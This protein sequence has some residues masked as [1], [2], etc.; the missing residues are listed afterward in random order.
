M[1]TLPAPDPSDR[2]LTSDVYASL[3]LARTPGATAGLSLRSCSKNTLA[4]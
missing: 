1:I 2:R 3:D 4:W